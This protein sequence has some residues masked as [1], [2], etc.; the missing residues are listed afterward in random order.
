MKWWGWIGIVI[1]VV[2]LNLNFE[3]DGPPLKEQGK[4]TGGEFWLGLLAWML[5]WSAWQ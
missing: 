4:V 2:G 5:F 1:V 3:E